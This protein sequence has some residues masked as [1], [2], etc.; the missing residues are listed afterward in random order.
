MRAT[1]TGDNGKIKIDRKND[2]P[3]FK[4]DEFSNISGNKP[5]GQKAKNKSLAAAEKLSKD[6]YLKKHGI[7]K[8]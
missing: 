1:T 7:K 5:Q 4:L 2:T 3:V 6:A 8:K